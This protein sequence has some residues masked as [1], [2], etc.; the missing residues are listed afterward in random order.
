MSGKRDEAGNV[1]GTT[2]VG[3]DLVKRTWRVGTFGGSGI[4]P[5]E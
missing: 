5:L 1:L 2:V 4:S 3:R